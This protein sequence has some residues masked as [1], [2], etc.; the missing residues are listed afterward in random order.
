MLEDLI[1]A[2][3]VVIP[4]R[5]REN[6]IGI[7][8]ERVLR[9]TPPALLTILLAVSGCIDSDTSHKTSVTLEEI[10]LK[11]SDDPVEN[12]I[13]ADQRVGTAEG[14]PGGCNIR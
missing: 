10:I 14:D 5:M 6:P 8:I 9:A 4:E 3:S 2:I 11:S 13:D 12:S 7:G 1:V